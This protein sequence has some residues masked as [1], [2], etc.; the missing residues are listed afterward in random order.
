MYVA[1]CQPQ[2][3]KFYP[4]IKYP[5]SNQTPIISPLIKWDHKTSWLIPKWTEKESFGEFI[6][7]NITDQEWSYLEGHVIDGKNL[8]PVAS[9][10]VCETIAMSF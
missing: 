7:I 3:K 5:V 4:E 2:L 6:T 9:Y 8:M 10:V 1:G